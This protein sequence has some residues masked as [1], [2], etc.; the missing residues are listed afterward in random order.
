M[1][2]GM[3]Q[4]SRLLAAAI[5]LSFVLGCDQG[6]QIEKKYPEDT[7]LSRTYFE[8]LQSGQYERVENDFDSMITNRSDFRTEFDEMVATIP[9]ENALSVTP[10]W[11]RIDCDHGICVHQIILEYRYKNELLL[12][13][14]LIRKAG[15]LSSIVGMNIR[16][17][18]ESAITASEFR[19]SDKGFPQYAV[20]LM[21]IF[22]PVFSL[23]VLVLCIRSKIGLRKWLW[24]VFILI[25]V[26]R[27]GVNWATGQP[28]FQLFAIQLFSAAASAET[29]GPW[30]VSV[31]IPLGA[32]LFLLDQALRARH[33]MR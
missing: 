23:Y 16:V 5:L 33:T 28:N 27:L 24:A 11:I 29:Y 18:P 1:Q 25:G 30:T 22:F 4:H 20:L 2:N 19:L 8:F 7:S 21:A 13:N 32:I 31:S 6:T 14:V 12:F 15:A 9:K 10:K 3:K 26:S 17:I